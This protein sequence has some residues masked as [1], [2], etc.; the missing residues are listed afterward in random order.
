MERERVQS[1]HVASVDVAEMGG[2]GD[3][4]RG[5]SSL[6]WQAV[7]QAWQGQQLPGQLS[8]EVWLCE[9]FLEAHSIINFF[10]PPT[11]SVSHLIACF[12][13]LNSN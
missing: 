5:G 2:P 11:N 12:L 13:Q 3:S 9:L 8:S 6:M 7:T 4:S 10:S 1:H